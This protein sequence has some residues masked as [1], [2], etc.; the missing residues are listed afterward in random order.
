MQLNNHLDSCYRIANLDMLQLSPS[1][2]AIDKVW[3]L[4]M[5][6]HRVAVKNLNSLSLSKDKEEQEPELDPPLERVRSKLII[7][8]VTVAGI[9]VLFEACTVLYTKEIFDPGKCWNTTHVGTV[10]NSKS[11]NRDN[12]Y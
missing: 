6:R 4:E 7:G 10:Q 3:D 5:R 1:D 2:S 8:G 11:A 12:P 9:H